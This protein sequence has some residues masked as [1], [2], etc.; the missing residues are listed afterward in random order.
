[1]KDV[2][3]YTKQ[4]KIYNPIPVQIR[5]C[6]ESAL[7]KAEQTKCTLR[8]PAPCSCVEFGKTLEITMKVLNCLPYSIRSVV[9]ENISSLCKYKSYVVQQLKKQYTCQETF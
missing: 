3:E 5:T 9:S 1:M 2:K 7:L 8:Q 6:A 4:F